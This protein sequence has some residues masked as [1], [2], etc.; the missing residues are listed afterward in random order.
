MFKPPGME[1]KKE[2]YIS[3]LRP[4][5]A[6][7]NLSPSQLREANSRKKAAAGMNHADFHLRH[8]SPLYPI[9]P[10]SRRATIVHQYASAPIVCSMPTQQ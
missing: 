5:R 10:A 8:P 3:G 1:I 9:A 6:V 2:E 7:Y 4:C